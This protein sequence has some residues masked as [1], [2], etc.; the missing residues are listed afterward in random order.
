MNLPLLQS[1]AS[2]DLNLTTIPLPNIIIIV[3]AVMIMFFA[4]LFV[5]VKYVK[6]IGPVDLEK[7]NSVESSVY[8]MNREIFNVDSDMGA[9]VRSITTSLET[10]L[11]NI[12]YES[13]ICPVAVIALT[14]SALRPLYNSISNNHFTTVMQPSNRDNY[15]NGLL[16]A[17][18]DQYRSTYNAMLNFE[19]GDKKVSMPKWDDTNSGEDNSPKMRV[20]KFLDEWVDGVTTETIKSC[21]RKIEIFKSYEKSF[22]G[23]AYRTNILI[24]CIT[25]NE[26]YI[27]LLDRH[28]KNIF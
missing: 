2:V 24:S 9:R 5:I 13:R 23:N 22:K 16:R 27:S 10:R 6:K 1:G 28:G 25:K 20:E 11:R 12:F 7:E 4:L 15:L 21:L 26:K 14:N 8:E 3:A 18:E 17:I 19:C